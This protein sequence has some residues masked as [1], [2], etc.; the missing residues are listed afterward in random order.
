MSRVT[1]LLLAAGAA[2]RMGAAKLSLDVCGKALAQYAAEAALASRAQDVIL[3]TG[4]QR[5]RVEAALRALPLHTVWNARWQAG[6]SAS[7][8]CGLDAA[9]AKT[10]GPEAVLVLL[11]D[12]PLVTADLLNRLVELH[13]AGHTLAACDTG[14]ALGPP[15]LFDRAHFDAL[16]TLSGDRGAQ[17]L[18]EGAAP[19]ARIPFA[20]GDIDTPEDLAR[21]R[22]HFAKA[23][24]EAGAA[25]PTDEP[26]R[27]R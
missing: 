23:G 4:A 6:L 22:A 1:A 13:E 18:L 27:R 26:P 3:V 16:R 10:P 25:E 20:G 21:L 11:A 14:A 17:G 12:Q 19:E 2:R 5:K 8:R 24:A 15:A 9:C 7:L